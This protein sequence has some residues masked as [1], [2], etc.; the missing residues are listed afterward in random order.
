[1]KPPKRGINL[2]GGLLDIY[3]TD[4]A[5]NFLLWHGNKQLA[6]S[7]KDVTIIQGGINETR[8]CREGLVWSLGP[9]YWGSYRNDHW[10]LVGWLDD[11]GHCP[12]DDRRGGLGE[13]GGDLRRPI[14]EA[15][16]P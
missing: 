16:E 14:Y 1:M 15:S 3:N 13:S 6:N 10:L 9:Y 7:I 11:R 8:N 2:F 12:K 5:G 4:Y